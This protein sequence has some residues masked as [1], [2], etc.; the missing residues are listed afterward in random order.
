MDEVQTAFYGWKFQVA[1]LEKGSSSELS[2]LDLLTTHLVPTKGDI[3]CN[4]PRLST[5]TYTIA[6]FQCYA[7]DHLPCSIAAGRSST[8]DAT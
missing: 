6:I 4:G 3:K 5:Y 7:P 1:H 8:A 2:S